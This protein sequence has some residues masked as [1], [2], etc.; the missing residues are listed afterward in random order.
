MSDELEIIL[1]FV[2]DK[3][4]YGPILT[5][6]ISY[7]IYRVI[8]AGLKGIIEDKH[9]NSYENKRKKTVVVLITN[10]VKILIYI[11]DSLIIL[12]I[13]NVNTTSIL[14]S[15]GIASAVI[16]LAFQD[17]LKD[18]IAGITIILENYFIVGD[19]VRYGDYMGEVISFGFKSTKIRNWNNEILTVSNRNI[20][21]IV[22]LSKSKAAVVIIVP[23]AY[24][25]DVD[26]VEKALMDILAKI[27]KLEYVE[28]DS[29]QYAGIDSFESSSVN[30]VIRFLTDHDKQWQLRRDA[31]VIIKKEL[32]KKG[33][34]IPY[35]QIEVHNGKKL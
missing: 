24:E 11:I 32:D 7:L 26:I 19:Y 29:M 9:D 4:I 15:L 25:I 10:F 20:S 23:I 17:A 12:S 34:K 6:I 30:Y 27:E 31:L 33:I 14:A 3:R 1:S 22:N 21:Q 5:I 18:I 2:Q 16:G 13:Y 8:K 35:N 28:K